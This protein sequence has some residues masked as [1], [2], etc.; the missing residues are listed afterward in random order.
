ME[1]GGMQL[2]FSSLCIPTTKRPVTNLGVL[3][4]L[5]GLTGAA[6]GEMKGQV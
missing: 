6:K 3:D 4:T 1:T 2:V 5:V